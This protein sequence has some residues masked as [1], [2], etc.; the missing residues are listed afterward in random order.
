M[1]YFKVSCKYKVPKPWSTHASMFCTPMLPQ[2]Q[3][4]VL[5]VLPLNSASALDDGLD[6]NYDILPNLLTWLRYL[7]GE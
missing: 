3:T 7:E 4:L 6:S 1:G 5:S 2:C